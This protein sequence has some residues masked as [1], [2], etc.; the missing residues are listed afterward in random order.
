MKKSADR[1]SSRGLLWSPS[2]FFTPEE[3]EEEEEEDVLLW[4]PSNS[5]LCG[6]NEKFTTS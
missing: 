1:G 2:F 4:S 5:A 6:A 3:E